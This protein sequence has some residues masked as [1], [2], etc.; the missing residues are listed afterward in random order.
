MM[1]YIAA[2]A[3]SF[4]SQP[5]PFARCTPNSLYSHCAHKQHES[6]EQPRHQ[7]R[8]SALSQHYES[9]NT[10]T[11]NSIG[12]FYVTENQLNRTLDGKTLIVSARGV[13]E[14]NN[15]LPVMLCEGYLAKRSRNDE[16]EFEIHMI[17]PAAA[18]TEPFFDAFIAVLHR[19]LLDYLSYEQLAYEH[20]RDSGRTSSA[21]TGNTTSL[22]II[23][24]DDIHNTEFMTKLQN[25]G[26]HNDTNNNL[27]FELESYLPFLNEYVI[28][29]RGT[30]HGNEA[31]NVIKRMCQRRVPYDF[32]SAS[33]YHDSA[34]VSL[35]KAL[36]PSSTIQSVME[37]VNEIKSNQMLS[38]NP[39]SVDGLPSLHL[40]L[41]SDGEPLFDSK[42]LHNNDC[43][44]DKEE[45]D[46][47]SASFAECI[48]Q[49]TE[50]LQPYLYNNVL[51]SVQDLLNSSNVTISD[52]FIRNYGQTTNGNSNE[53]TARYTLS[54]HYDI[55]AM[56]TCVIALD[57]TASTGKNG[58]YTIPPCN[59]GSA[60]NN[61]ALRRFFPLDKGD[62]IVHTFDVLHGVD[63]DPELNTC[64][65]SL[66]VWF[67]SNITAADNHSWLDGR[68][69]DISQFVKGLVLEEEDVSNECLDMYIASA[70]R[71][72]M[73]AIT[74]LAQLCSEGKV[75]ESLYERIQYLIPCNIFHPDENEGA[76]WC[77][78]DLANALWYHASVYGSNPVAQNGLARSLMKQYSSAGRTLSCEDQE[79]ILLIASVL[80]T[81][82]YNNNNQDSLEALEKI[83]SME[84][85]RLCEEDVEIPSDEFF[86]SRIVQTLLLSLG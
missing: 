67:G 2:M 20:D 11:L 69:D 22:K 79:H 1:Y 14:H 76:T 5:T 35:Q 6:H 65:T 34:V 4:T 21:P 50:I 23:F 16:S 83:M 54:P 15:T 53:Q 81:M 55:T 77:C 68:N 58:L 84:C 17:L 42:I 49:L 56:A 24:D 80:F 85:Q 29:H 44:D 57:A 39:D 82:A 8:E 66:I 41:I 47:T 31:L 33:K 71:E 63:V 52:A 73:F 3:M 27:G 78:Q 18:A 59:N 38:M 72:N 46:T 61:P 70:S 10:V 32:S 13:N 9:A 75:P 37:I 26:F 19:L 45:E 64:R 25:I 86:S 30:E 48:S 74:A 7:Y 62:G 51:P 28:R 40:N 60:S 43:D 12:D 36:L